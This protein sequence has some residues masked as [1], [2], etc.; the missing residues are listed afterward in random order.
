MEPKPSAP[1]ASAVP[2]LALASG[3]AVTSTPVTT[4]PVA[5]VAPS[6]VTESASFLAVGASSR[7]VRLAPSLTPALALSPSLSVTV[8]V[9]VMTSAARPTGSFALLRSPC[10]SARFWSSVTRP[11]A[12]TLTAKA[13]A[14]FASALSATPSA[15]LVPT[16]PTTVPPSENRKTLAPVAVSTTPEATP[17]SEATDRA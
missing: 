9:R 12:S 5:T 8:A 11:L 4:L 1:R 10:F 2:S 16:R 15:P 3:F 14:P 13:T 7:K 17:V 6:S